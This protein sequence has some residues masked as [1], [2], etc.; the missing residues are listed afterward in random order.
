MG[1][2]TLGTYDKN[3]QYN[4]GVFGG[5]LCLKVYLDAS[6]AVSVESLLSLDSFS[7]KRLK[8]ALPSFYK[9]DISDDALILSSVLPF[10]RKDTELFD[11]MTCMVRDPEML[12]F[13]YRDS[14]VFLPA[15]NMGRS[16]A[17]AMA[18]ELCKRS[19]EEY[20][21]LFCC[22]VKD[23]SV[24]YVGF[25]GARNMLVEDSDIALPVCE[26]G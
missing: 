14:V 18:E 13:V 16:I 26:I 6:D 10:V 9:F 3:A 24:D 12:A 23:R 21:G 15:A 2:V 20:S 17:Q 25:E 8:D 19:D 7:V 4:K 11:T 22:N 1:Y 5:D